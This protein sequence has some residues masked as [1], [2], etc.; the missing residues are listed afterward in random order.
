MALN[1]LI[2]AVG[3]TLFLILAITMPAFASLPDASDLVSYYDFEDQS[4]NYLDL[5]GNQNVTAPTGTDSYSFPSGREVVQDRAIQGVYGWTGQAVQG[6]SGKDL[7]WS[8]NT[9][10]DI[11]YAWNDTFSISFF[12]KD[13]INGNVDGIEYAWL[14]RRSMNTDVMYITG[15]DEYP[16]T[17]EADCASTASNCFSKYEGY[18]V[19]LIEQNSNDTLVRFGT[20][21][22]GTSSDEIHSS[23]Q[24]S[25]G[26]QYCYGEITT[27]EHAYRW[28]YGTVSGATDGKAPANGACGS[29]DSGSASNPYYLMTGGFYADTSGS[30]Y[31]FR[32][33]TPHYYSS[34]DVADIIE[35]DD[36]ADGTFSQIESNDD[37]QDWTHYVLTFDNGT[38]RTYRSGSLTD[39]NVLSGFNSSNN[40]SLVLGGTNLSGSEVNSGSHYGNVTRI[41]QN[42]VSG[43]SIT[44]SQCNYYHLYSGNPSGAMLYVNSGCT[45]TGYTNENVPNKPTGSV[46]LDEVSIW[47][48]TLN[49]QEVLDMS[50][51]AYYSELTEA[52]L[53]DVISYHQLEESQAPYSD[54]YSLFD[55]TSASQ[56]TQVPGKIGNG[57]DFLSG[58]N[59]KIT[60]PSN[61]HDYFDYNT[62]WSINLWILEDANTTSDGIFYGSGTYKFNTTGTT[63]DTS[64][65]NYASNYSDGAWRMMTWTFDEFD[66]QTIYIDGVQ[67]AT[68]SP[69]TSSW[70]SSVDFAY[71]GLNYN[72]MIIDEIGW[73]SRELVQSDIDLLYNSGAGRSLAGLGGLA[74]GGGSGSG[75]GSASSPTGTVQSYVGFPSHVNGTCTFD[76]NTGIFEMTYDDSTQGVNYAELEVYEWEFGDRNLLGT[77]TSTLYQDTLQYNVSSVISSGNDAQAF[78]YINSSNTNSYGGS[79]YLVCDLYADGGNEIAQ[80]IGKENAVG[81]GFFILLTFLTFGLLFRSAVAVLIMGSVGFLVLGTFFL[82]INQTVIYLVVALMLLI[83]W[84]MSRR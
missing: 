44:K 75:G 3:G 17:R 71:D 14:D 78:G 55:L 31:N 42:D 7:S 9:I 25:S 20:D 80:A 32:R 48:K 57:Q 6:Q 28:S 23:V 52:V 18:D 13:L 69:G 43:G 15:A 16:I 5:M 61:L 51:G 40:M 10:I 74:Q 60:T 54:S 26:H 34:I 19:H 49:A 2:K 36:D 63:I 58:S 27:L 77:D 37:N 22:V 1:K 21:F 65:T 8:G 84:S 35:L 53:H 81:Y 59:N 73:W 76:S 29:Y 64:T 68:A 46:A 39:T 45:Y 24:F 33:H 79:S 38:M 11:P 56:P 72:D 47:N 66:G 41:Y 82:N 4:G 62:H 67:V 12:R 50:A 70:K 83:M 30:P